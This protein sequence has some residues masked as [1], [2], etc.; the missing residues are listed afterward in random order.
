MVSRKNLNFKYALV[1]VYNKNKLGFLCKNLKK[2][3]YKF[4][5]TGSTCKKIRDLGFTTSELKDI[6]ESQT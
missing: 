5:S 4:L 3:D 2:Y 1:S 6:K